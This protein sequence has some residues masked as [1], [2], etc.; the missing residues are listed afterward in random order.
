ML[1]DV[2]FYGAI[3]ITI[4][5]ITGTYLFNQQCFDSL[6]ALCTVALLIESVIV[7]KII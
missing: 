3:F 6:Q 5:F 7:E 1:K 2:I 4:L